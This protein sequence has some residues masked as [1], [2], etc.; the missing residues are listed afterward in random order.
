MTFLAAAGWQRTVAFLC[1]LTPCACVCDS[2]ALPP[3]G[4][5]HLR[6]DVDKLRGQLAPVLHVDGHHRQGAR[7]LF[8]RKILQSSQNKKKIRLNNKQ[9][10]VWSSTAA[11]RSASATSGWVNVSLGSGG[12]VATS[13]SIFWRRRDLRVGSASFATG[14]LWGRKIIPRGT[15]VRA[16][17]NRSCEGF[18]SSQPCNESLQHKQQH[19]TQ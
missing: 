9:T 13:A 5:S 6:A 15:A 17:F 1:M 11:L 2:D 12:R 4:V 18:S 16:S 8:E 7:W 10:I 14:A 3:E 19:E